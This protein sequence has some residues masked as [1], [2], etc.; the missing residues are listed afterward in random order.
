MSVNKCYHL[1]FVAV[2]QRDLMDCQFVFNNNILSGYSEA[3][4]L[5]ACVGR[6]PALAN[7]QP[8]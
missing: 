1:L 3:C 8:V 6:R 2:C 4:Q 7:I 5:S